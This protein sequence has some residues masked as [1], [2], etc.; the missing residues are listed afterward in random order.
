[1]GYSMCYKQPFPAESKIKHLKSHVKL[2]FRHLDQLL[3]NFPIVF[4]NCLRHN[5]YTRHDLQW[6]LHHQFLVIFR[7]IFVCDWC[8]L[9]YL[10]SCVLVPL[11]FM[12]KYVSSSKMK[13]LK[14]QWMLL[15]KQVSDADNYLERTFM[16]PASVRAGKLISSWLEDAGLR[17]LVLFTSILNNI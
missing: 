15:P 11:I 5:D 14:L 16:S 7:I 10:T 3:F 13:V 9:L 6:T 1:M 2:L 8:L 17:T 12:A 4:F